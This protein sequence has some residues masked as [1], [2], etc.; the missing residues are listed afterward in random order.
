MLSK[1]ILLKDNL[2]KILKSVLPK[3]NSRTLL[4]CF[5]HLP[6]IVTTLGVLSLTFRHWFWAPPS[7]ST[8]TILNALQFAAQLHSSLIIMSLS[9]MIMRFVHYLLCTKD[10]I[11]IGFLSSPF[12]LNSI[13]Y[14]FTKEFSNLFRND[15]KRSLLYV[16]VFIFTFTL[17]MLAG[18]SSAITMIPRLQFWPLQ[19][20]LTYENNLILRVYIQ[21]RES[22][23]FPEN[24]TASGV[25][26]HCSG[27]EAMLSPSCPS[28][29]IRNFLADDELFDMDIAGKLMEA[30]STMNIT[31]S[32]NWTRYIAGVIDEWPSSNPWTVSTTPGFVG[33]VLQTYATALENLLDPYYF[34]LPQENK[35]LAR[36]DFSLNSAGEQLPTRKPIV[37][38]VCSGFSPSTT[39]VTFPYVSMKLPEDLIDPADLP[40]WTI[41]STAYPELMFSGAHPFSPVNVTFIP[42]SRFPSPRPSLLT[43]FSTPEVYDGSCAYTGAGC[44]DEGSLLFANTS[45]IACSVDARWMKTHASYDWSNGLPTIYDTNPT[46]DCY[47][48]SD[49]SDISPSMPDYPQ[50]YIDSSFTSFLNPP[51]TDDTPDSVLSNQTLLQALG[52]KCM[53]TN[54]F[55]ADNI[56]GIPFPDNGTHRIA[57]SYNAVVQCL[58]TAF[59]F[60]LA[61]ALSH[62]QDAIPVYLVGEGE[63]VVF[64]EEAFKPVIVDA[65]AVNSLYDYASDPGDPSDFLVNLDGS[66]SIQNITAKDLHD[67]SR[68][69]EIRMALSRYGYGYGFTDSKLIC[70]GVTVLSLHLLLCVVHVAWTFIEWWRGCAVSLGLRTVGELVAIALRSDPA[71]IDEEAQDWDD[72]A[73]KGKRKLWTQRVGVRVASVG[74]AVAEGKGMGFGAARESLVLRKLGKGRDGDEDNSDF[75]HGNTK[76]RDSESAPREG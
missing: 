31:I 24:L 28:A 58:Q 57:P 11:P 48:P 62:A 16:S 70:V 1:G 42:P 14:V 61:D 40:H 69:I 23:L 22:D 76:G 6:S 54:T 32:G 75:D 29:G 55:A 56:Q 43:L 51:Y 73:V 8:N 4:R 52:Q 46:P 63:T 71:V 39:Q 15:R 36:Y 74:D 34:G 50:F 68:F 53:D 17:A 37:Q 30:Q 41:N 2:P 72:S 5:I 18:P 25:S 19:I 26:P 47:G 12:Q 64:D 44:S 13:S 66:G 38:M 65:L 7:S 49:P 9:A 45:L 33:Q 20:P 35:G 3:G 59:S 21:A 10:G 27:S 60:Y 67:P